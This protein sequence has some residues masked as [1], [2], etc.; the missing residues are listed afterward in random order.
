MNWI[1]QLLPIKMFEIEKKHINKDMF[2]ANLY[3]DTI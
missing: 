1:D 2:H 3:L